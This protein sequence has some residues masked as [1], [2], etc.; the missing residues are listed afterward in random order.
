ML[1]L[2]FNFYPLKLLSNS[3]Q[4]NLSQQRIL[5]ANMEIKQWTTCIGWCLQLVCDTNSWENNEFT[6]WEVLW[7]R[8]L[9]VIW[10]DRG[11]TREK[12]S[13][14]THEY[15]QNLTKRGDWGESSKPKF[16]S[17]KNMEYLR[18]ENFAV[19]R[20]WTLRLER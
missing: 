2:W 8:W 15:T 16:R 12:T 10:E 14:M 17:R 13:Q 7:F 9:I 1:L 11:G 5:K 20:W 4:L 18:I 19:G 3:I 6:V